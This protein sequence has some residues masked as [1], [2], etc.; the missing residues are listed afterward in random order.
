MKHNWLVIFLLLIST[1]LSALNGCAPKTVLEPARTENPDEL[2]AKAEKSFETGAYAAAWEQYQVYLEK[3]P[4]SPLA[5][6][7]LMKMGKIK[8]WQG[9]Y[10]TARTYFEKILS[11]FPSTVFYSDAGVEVL[12]MLFEQARYS[13]LIHRA[14][15]LP[16]EKLNRIQEVR[17]AMLVGDSFLA[18]DL[19][20]EAVYSFIH[21]YERASTT[22][23]ET[24]GRK[25]KAALLKLNTA[26]ILEVA[27]KIQ[28]PALKALVEG[29][30][31]TAAFHPEVIGCLLPL[32]GQYKEFGQRA[33]KGIELAV[34]QFGSS[35]G[36]RFKMIVKDSGSEAGSTAKGV[37]ALYDEK[38]SC[39]IGPLVE[40]I[41]AVT[42]A[43]E[44]KIPI[45]A[46]SQKEGI[47]ETGDY[48]F[49]NFI[50]P[51]MQVSALVSYAVNELGAQRFAVLYPREKYGTTFMNLFWGAVVKH[52]RQ[53]VGAEPYDPGQTDF[54]EPL[55]KLAGLFRYASKSTGTAGTSPEGKATETNPGRTYSG[56]TDDG[57]PERIQYDENGNA[58]VFKKT[59][60]LFIP[61]SPKLAGLIIPQLAY[62][63]VDNVIIMGSNLWHS[64]EFIKMTGAYAQGAVITDGFFDQSTSLPVREFVD[65]FEGIYGSKPGFFEAVA[66]DTA[67]MLF[68]VLSNPGIRTRGD[69]RDGL[70]K[71]PH[72]NG[73]TGK[74]A[75][76]DNGDAEKELFLLELRNDKFIEIRPF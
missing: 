69:I 47:P 55:K 58:F 52:E 61:D 41:L 66:Y 22:E 31:Q 53:M 40:P 73:V 14:T 6:G 29:A 37:Q 50:T 23:R 51:E 17:V 60:V 62:H 34:H 8:A 18:M 72:F 11:D 36:M 71:M 21:G 45:I 56:V 76:K 19:P 39:I 44:L 63:D 1:A 49:R 10:E 15:D 2:F 3:F 7:A 65:A 75:F 25:I 30:Q 42:K 33:L 70:L 13:D 38:A 9:D 32:S 74:T 26:E 28:D 54:A 57:D 16:K 35:G 4:G 27:K 59:D 12:E 46:L 43:Q 68:K 48:V 64:D 20:M 5:P 67:M 24:L